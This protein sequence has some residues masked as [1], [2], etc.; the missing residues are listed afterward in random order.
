MKFLH[1]NNTA[2]SEERIV[3]RVR[4]LCLQWEKPLQIAVS[5]WG[6]HALVTTRL[7]ERIEE[8]SSEPIQVLCDLLSG[9]CN[10]EPIE[11]LTGKP[12]EIVQVKTLSG[13]HAKV[14]ICADHV[15]IGSANVSANG[16]GFD[17]K[18]ST[19]GNVEAAVEV[20]DLPFASR[21]QNWF[22]EQWERADPVDD[23]K[24]KQAKERWNKRRDSKDINKLKVFSNELKSRNSVVFK[25]PGTQITDKSER[26]KVFYEGLFLALRDTDILGEVTP[27]IR[28]GCYFRSGRSHVQ[29]AVHFGVH[30]R[31]RVELYLNRL[32]DKRWNKS[33]FEKIKQHKDVIQNRIGFDEE[34]EWERLDHRQISRVAIYRSGNIFDNEEQLV[35]IQRWFV[36][37]LIAFKRAFEPY[38][39]I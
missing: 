17:D 27:P 20:C 3:D 22:N 36:K 31:V 39:D 34:L 25:V 32:K 13:L 19:E 14:W 10:P 18:E 37:N 29:F 9:S 23:E 8:K 11:V 7:R 4:S 38:L 16:L 33:K 2:N 1:S 15:I 12:T 26:Y 21:V 6:E 5:Y 30:G 24:I 35:E 28:S